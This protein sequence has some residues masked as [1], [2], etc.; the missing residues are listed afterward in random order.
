[1]S[2]LLLKRR[3]WNTH[4][5]RPCGVV[6]ALNWTEVERENRSFD[7]FDL[8]T[9]IQ[10]RAWQSAAY[11]LLLFCT[12]KRVYFLLFWHFWWLQLL[13]ISWDKASWVQQKQSERPIINVFD[14]Q[15]Y[16]YN[17]TMWLKSICVLFFCFI[18]TSQLVLCYFMCSRSWIFIPVWDQAEVIES[19]MWEIF[20]HHFIWL[21]KLV[22]FKALFF[23]F[24]FHANFRICYLL[25]LVWESS[26][27][28]LSS[29]LSPWSL[30]PI[31][32]STNKE[33][34]TCV[35]ISTDPTSL[36][37]SCRDSHLI[38][39]KACFPSSQLHQPK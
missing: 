10:R 20:K 5:K 30:L 1:M 6:N 27:N 28:A 8:I 7:S 24:I 21:L 34:A 29:Q 31:R 26:G 11:S 33:D 19:G 3:R 14:C 36:H 18:F 16:K 12:I 22:K 38:S 15:L 23:F 13:L 9:E 4:A 37:P 25:T 2:F 17:F 35:P 39:T 32:M